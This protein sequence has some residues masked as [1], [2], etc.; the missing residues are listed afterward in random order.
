MTRKQQ[1]WVCVQSFAS[2]L[3][4]ASTCLCAELSEQVRDTE[5]EAT[6]K[7][8]SEAHQERVHSLSRLTQETR[9]N[10]NSLNKTTR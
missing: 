10:V 8:A 9:E 1:L 6:P 3:Q 7:E 4:K 5:E 2:L